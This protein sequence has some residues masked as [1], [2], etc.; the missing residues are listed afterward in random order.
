MSSS[1]VQLQKEDKIAPLGWH[2]RF[3]EWLEAWLPT[4]YMHH[5]CA[6]GIGVDCLRFVVSALDYLHGTEHLP[7]CPTLPRDT[8]F[9]RRELAFEV[10]RWVSR[11]YANDVMLRR[12]GNPYAL[13]LQPGDVV[14]TNNDS[15]TPAH[16]MI[17]GPEKN[18]LWHSI[19]GCCA[20]TN[21]GVET[22]GLGW[23]ISRGIYRVFRP[24]RIKQ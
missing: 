24:T 23:A 11:H 20:A 5:L 10:V 13:D 3:A 18:I 16:I 7:N 1:W 14:V 17:G 9:H 15:N 2:R 4:P 21:G 12:R 19:D 22:T 6:R 8:S